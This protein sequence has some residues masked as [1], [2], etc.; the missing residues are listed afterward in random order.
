VSKLIVSFF[1][2]LESRAQPN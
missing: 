1:R 2:R